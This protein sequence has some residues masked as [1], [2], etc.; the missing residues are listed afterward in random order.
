MT[1]KSVIRT[2]VETVS[3]LSAATVGLGARLPTKCAAPAPARIA[4]AWPIRAGTDVT[5]GRLLRA[6]G[7]LAER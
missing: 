5:D 6:L 3:D 2:A 1:T 4:A 7:A